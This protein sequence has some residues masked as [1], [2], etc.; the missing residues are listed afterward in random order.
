VIINPI[1]GMGGAVGLK[2]TD[3]PE[4]L[5]RARALGAQPHSEERAETALRLI[6]GQTAAIEVFAGPG[7]MGENA[8][9]A[10]GFSPIAI[11][12]PIE[13]DST[14]ADTRRIAAIMA[15][16]NL[17]LL[18][19]A[20]GDGAARDVFAAI[21]S[22]ALALGVPTGVKMHS[23]VYATS[24]R[25]AGELAA[26][27]LRGERTGVREAEVMDIDEDAFRS[28]RVSARL[29]GYL[30]TPAARGLMQN[31][32]S[33]GQGDAADLAGIATEI[34]ER[35]NDGALWVIGPGATTRA[36][37]E[38]AGL[39]KTLLGVDLYCRGEVI[40]ADAGEADIL[41]HVA[42]VPSWI[43][44]TPIGGQGA[45]FGRGN[46]QIS[47]AV[48]RAA[49]RERIVV[50]AAMA[51]LVSLRGAPLLVDTGDAGLDRELAGHARVVTGYRAETIQRIAP[52]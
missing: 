13:G 40:A 42:R 23:A 25:A 6:A 35:I 29:F 8:A 48:I 1:A 19:F 43:V 37:A 20:G 21:G 47:A 27:V 31:L 39:P 4:A 3:G 26:Q 10:A 18:L 12:G 52:A 17:D 9:R 5:A 45:L 41:T 44:V 49:G 34:T 36:I 2:G 11:G 51:K 32:K 22:S 46:Q 15:G 28:G 16:L 14:A 33:G 50:V 30:R 38:R 24:P 7:A